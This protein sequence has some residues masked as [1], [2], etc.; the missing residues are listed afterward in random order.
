MSDNAVKKD[1]YLEGRQLEAQARQH[2]S[3]STW[4]TFAEVK[5]SK[6]SYP[7]ATMGYLNAAI[8]LEASANF[9]AAI[10]AYNSG[11]KIAMKGKLKEPVLFLAYR[12]AALHERSA[13]FAQA[14]VVYEQ[15]ADYFEIQEA[16]FLAA[17]ASE[18]AA[19]MLRAA[20]CNLAGYRRPADLWL[21][22][23]EYWV[24]KDTGDEAWSRHRAALY[25]QKIQQ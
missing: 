11:L 19:E 15:L 7:M 16:W 13:A 5:A 22:N 12:L 9:A 14:A 2:N 8:A 21:R 10:D 6:G 24:G 17:D 4:L 1:S 23:A 3:A 20:G 18:H 25:E